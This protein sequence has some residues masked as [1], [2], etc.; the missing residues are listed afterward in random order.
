MKFLN[1]TIEF[2]SKISSKTLKYL[3]LNPHLA[4]AEIAL[5]LAKTTFYG[6]KCRYI[7]TSTGRQVLG[8]KEQKSTINQFIETTSRELIEII[9]EQDTCKNNNREQLNLAVILCVKN[10]S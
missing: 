4:Y 1:E 5:K 9:S 10:R 8:L 6:K 7:G 2:D 3:I